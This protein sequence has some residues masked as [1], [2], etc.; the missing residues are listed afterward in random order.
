MTD[1]V[2]TIRLY[3]KLGKRFGRVHR[4]A[5]NSAAEA[6]RALGS[7]LRGFDAYLTQ[8]KDNGM[9]YAV[10]YGKRN[11]GE[12]NLHD[13]SGGTDIRFAPVMLG[14]KNGGWLQIVLGAV[15]VV[16]GSACQDGLRH[17][18]RRRGATADANTERYQRKGQAGESAELRVQWPDQHASAGKPGASAVRRTDRRQCCTICWNQCR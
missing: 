11:I 18:Y 7:Q 1:I 14:R 4:L 15:L 9:A 6:V 2:R 17:D 13:P 5:V 8:S 12:E 3:G 16:A 10:F